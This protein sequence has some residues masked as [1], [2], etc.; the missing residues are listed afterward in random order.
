MLRL[1]S[2]NH[3]RPYPTLLTVPSLTDLIAIMHTELIIIVL[4]HFGYSA[5]F[6]MVLAVAGVQL[7]AIRSYK[8]A[9]D[10]LPLPSIV[11]TS[12]KITVFTVSMHL[13]GKS[14]HTY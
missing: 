5:G 11:E 1:P 2:A 10:H 12:Q 9:P 6:G 7:A 13:C 3:D 4:A 8:K 14:S